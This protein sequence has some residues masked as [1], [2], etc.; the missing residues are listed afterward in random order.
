MR[1][2][3]WLLTLLLLPAAATAQPRRCVGDNPRRT[4]ALER[5]IRNLYNDATGHRSGVNTAQL[6]EVIA[7]ANALCDEAGSDH[8]LYWL[9]L[10]RYALV[11]YAEA[12]RQLDAYLAAHPVE[13]LGRERRTVESLRADLRRHLARVQ[14]V[15]RPPGV[16]VRVADTL[17]GEVEVPREPGPASVTLTSPD[18][19]PLAPAPVLQLAAGTL[20]TLAITEDDRAPIPEGALRIVILRPLLQPLP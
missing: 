2:L 7:R 11:N 5:E 4:D 17:V 16:V 10:A 20:T 8:A 15:V 18:H 19:E 14:V 1:V 6:A 12:S 3:R 13:T 9:A